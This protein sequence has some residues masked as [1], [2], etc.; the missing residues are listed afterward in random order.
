MIETLSNATERTIRYLIPGIWIYILILILKPIDSKEVGIINLL[1]PTIGCGMIVYIFFRQLL[2]TF[3]HWVVNRA[4]AVKL[5]EKFL[6]IYQSPQEIG[7]YLNFKFAT[8]HTAELLPVISLFLGIYF[9]IQSLQACWIK[10]FF[11]IVNI[12]VFTSGVMNHYILYKVTEEIYKQIKKPEQ[13]LG[14]GE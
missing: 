14:Q 3:E 4:D 6:K 7:P 12:T 5:S 13:S 11:V 1:A 8:T 2:E 9:G 10:S